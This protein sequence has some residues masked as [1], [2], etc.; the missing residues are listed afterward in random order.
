ME[1]LEYYTPNEKYNEYMKQYTP[2]FN[3]RE[4]GN[5]IVKQLI[6]SSLV[7]QQRH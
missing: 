6:Q 5:G 7:N 2:E 1:C 3:F 4:S